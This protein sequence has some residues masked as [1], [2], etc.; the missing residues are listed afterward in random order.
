MLLKFLCY[1]SSMK[2]RTLVVLKPD[3]VKR[4]LIGEIIKRFERVGLKLVACKMLQVSREL[5]D[6]HYPL[7]RREFI[8]GMGKKTL[9]NYKDMGV[10]P[11]KEM[12]TDDPYEI[13][14]VIREWLVEMITSGPVLAMVWEGPHAVELVRKIT[15]HTL[16]LKAEP[17]TIRGDFSF[18]SSY[19][20]NTGKRAIKNLLH[21]SGDPEEAEY[22]INLWFSE[23][24]IHSYERAEE[25]VME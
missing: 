24:E 15:G 9:E 1:N 3:A 13:G 22:E 17:G 16:P 2:Q 12:G 25:K 11:I 14:K 7:S 5:A 19:L 20:A 21:A 10:D 18:D 23:D 4:G 6:K 8:E